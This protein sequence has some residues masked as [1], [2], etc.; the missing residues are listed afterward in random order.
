MPFGIRLHSGVFFSVLD[1]KVAFRERGERER[2]KLGNI[3][4]VGLRRKLKVG[5]LEQDTKS[6]TRNKKWPRLPASEREERL[7]FL[8][9]PSS[10]G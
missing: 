6:S 5:G 2:E 10:D 1:N 3:E 8:C 9:F 7:T 4:S